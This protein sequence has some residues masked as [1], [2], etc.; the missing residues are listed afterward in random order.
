MPPFDSDSDSISFCRADPSDVFCDRRVLVSDTAAVA[1]WWWC[2]SASNACWLLLCTGDQFNA[3]QQNLQKA[4]QVDIIHH[5]GYWQRA[6][7]KIPE[8]Y[9][10]LA[11]TLGRTGSEYL[12]ASH[13]ARAPGRWRRLQQ[14]AQ[15][16]LWRYQ[17]HEGGFLPWETPTTRLLKT[18]WTSCCS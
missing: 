5:L 9:E 15:A 14:T 13:T 3:K 4:G 17:L 6:A 8:C 1:W 10:Q 7:I 11:L 16:P 2:G 12:M 18:I